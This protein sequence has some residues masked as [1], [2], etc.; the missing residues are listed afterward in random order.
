MKFWVFYECF[1][2]LNLKTYNIF[3]PLGSPTNSDWPEGNV[4]ASKL[5]FK[6]PSSKGQKLRNLIPR[7]SEMAINFL[8]NILSLNPIKRLS[9]SQC[10]QHPFFQCYD[11]LSIYGLK[12]NNSFLKVNTLPSQKDNIEV[13]S[14]SN[15]DS[16]NI[17]NGN[18]HQKIK[19]T[20]TKET[21]N[22]NNVNS[23]NNPKKKVENSSV[24]N[25]FFLFYNK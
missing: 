6:F 7:A 21:T 12:T 22:T 8:E 11:I 4:L 5:N 17:F 25:M 13:N 23:E 24:N 9:A 10:L 16:N 14:N 20:F 1:I 15:Q 3:I 19:D 18:T 2:N